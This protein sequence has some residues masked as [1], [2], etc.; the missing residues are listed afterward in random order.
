LRA[1]ATKEFS[2]M[3]QSHLDQLLDPQTI[4]RAEA[5]GLQARFVVEGY[6]AGE[7]KSPYRGFAV[8]FAQ[9]REYTHGDDTRHLDWKVLAARTATTSSNTSR[10]RITS[11]TFSSMAASR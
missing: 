8:E 1:E 9:H 4:S 6:M 11:R 5:L 2:N 7:H 3:D 10:R